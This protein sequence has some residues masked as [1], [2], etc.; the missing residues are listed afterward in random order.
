M[1]QSATILLI[2][3]VIF[4]VGI[5]SY[6]RLGTGLG[7]LGWTLISVY[8]GVFLAVASVYLKLGEIERKVRDIQSKRNG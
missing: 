5:L 7:P 3:I 1:K 6:A 4:A 8:L 2:S